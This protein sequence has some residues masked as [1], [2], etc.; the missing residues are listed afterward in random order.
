MQ[1]FI[2]V[3]FVIFSDFYCIQYIII[4]KY[5]A[6]HFVMTGPPYEG[7]SKL[8]NLLLLTVICPL[9]FSAIMLVYNN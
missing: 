7:A 1:D 4:F 8:T 3:L 9:L 2:F 6:W 5:T